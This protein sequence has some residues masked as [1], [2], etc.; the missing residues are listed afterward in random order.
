MLNIVLVAAGGAIGSV[1]RYLVG[2]AAARSLGPAFP[3]GTLTVNLVGGFLIGLV[4]GV[5]AIRA[6]APQELRVFLITGCLGGFTTFSAFSLDVVTL[7]ERGDSGLAALYLLVSVGFSI[8]AVFA[9]L[10]LMR[11]IL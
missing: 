9:G 11:T 7:L 2:L 3:F 5:F 8:A 1:L 10:A 6:E 4:A